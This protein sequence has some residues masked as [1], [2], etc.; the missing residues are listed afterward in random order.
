MLFVDTTYSRA[1]RM[2]PPTASGDSRKDS[3]ATRRY[4]LIQKWIKQA[5]ASANRPQK[6]AP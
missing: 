5:L 4:A 3:Q 2:C 1:Y 6:N